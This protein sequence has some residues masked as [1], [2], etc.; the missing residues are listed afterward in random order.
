VESAIPLGFPDLPWHHEVAKPLMRGPVLPV[1][2]RFSTLRC[3]RGH[4]SPNLCPLC[5]RRSCPP[6][7]HRRL[8]IVAFFGVSRLFGAA[9]QIHGPKTM[10]QKLPVRAS[11]SP[12]RKMLSWPQQAV[13]DSNACVGIA[14][15]APMRGRGVSGIKA[16]S[17][18]GR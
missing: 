14:P 2:H 16:L 3:A 10:I 1:F 6:L 18:P 4:R 8:L 7:R 17:P 13:H 15:V 11:V 9:G 12:L 5:F